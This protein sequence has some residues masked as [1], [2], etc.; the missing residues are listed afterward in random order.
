MVVFT[1]QLKKFEAAYPRMIDQLVS[2]LISVAMVKWT[3][4]MKTYEN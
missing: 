4:Q 1:N 2:G 3:H